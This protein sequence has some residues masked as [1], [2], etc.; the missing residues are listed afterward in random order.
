[1]IGG[2]TA[3]VVELIVPPANAIS[4]ELPA[5]MNPTALIVPVDVT[6]RAVNDNRYVAPGQRET[7]CTMF[8]PGLLVV[9]LRARRAKP[10]GDEMRST[11]ASEDV[12]ATQGRSP[13]SKP[14]FWMRLA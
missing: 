4:A 13:V 12:S 2:T 10:G 7:L 9:P 11:I 8:D 1:L 14:G 5:C 6:R 3:K